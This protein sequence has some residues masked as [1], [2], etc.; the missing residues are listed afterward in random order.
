[1]A[2]NELIGS[3]YDVYVGEAIS[4]GGAVWTNDEAEAILKWVGEEGGGI[5]MAGNIR[6][7]K[8]PDDLWT[9]DKNTAN[10]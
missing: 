2:P 9:V 4:S 10:K 3:S 1:M 8:T 7:A 5:L 6:H